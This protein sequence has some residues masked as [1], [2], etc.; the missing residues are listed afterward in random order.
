M[1]E[2]LTEPSS[3]ASEKEKE[4]LEQNRHDSTDENDDDTD[5]SSVFSERRMEGPPSIRSPSNAH[6][7]R[8]TSRSLER[9]TTTASKCAVSNKI[10]ST[11]TGV[12]APPRAG[13]DYARRHR[14]LRWTGRSLSTCELA[15]PQEGHH[16]NPV[17][18]HHHGSNPW[19]KHL[20]FRNQASGTRIP[21]QHRS[22][23]SGH[24]TPTVRLRRW[25]I[26]M[27]T[28]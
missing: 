18:F 5:A 24:F 10:Q 21:R 20:L 19:I 4:D 15:V 23:Y 1:A 11:S 2:P 16:D 7:S 8:T 14:Q 13:K 26:D 9:A 12:H 3:S 28:T 25:T 27:G 22:H 6:L 17:R